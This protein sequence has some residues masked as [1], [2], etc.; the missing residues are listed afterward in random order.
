M[1]A[2]LA[3]VIV[4]LDTLLHRICALI[5]ACLVAPAFSSDAVNIALS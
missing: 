3:A 5:C 1:A 4:Y 2:I